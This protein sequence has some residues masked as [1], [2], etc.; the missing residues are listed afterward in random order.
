M[1]WLALNLLLFYLIEY[2]VLL[3]HEFG[4]VTAAKFV[5][6]RVLSVRIGYGRRLSKFTILGIPTIVNAIPL[7]GLTYAIPTERAW[8]KLKSWLFIAGGPAVHVIFLTIAFILS[9]ESFY[10]GY[11][12][13]KITSSIAP[14]ETFVLVNVVVL[15]LNIIPRRIGNPIGK[16]Y[17]DGYQLIVVPFLRSKQIDDL[18]RALPRVE[19]RELTREGNYSGAIEIYDRE[20]RVS[21]DDEL[22][23]HDRAIAVL[24]LGK[25]QE[26]QNTLLSLVGSESFT[27]KESALFLKNNIAWLD[28]VLGDQGDLSRADEYSESAYSSAPDVPMFCGTRGSVLIRLGRCDLG[29]NLLKRAFKVAGDPYARAAEA[30]FLALGHEMIGSRIDADKWLE[31]A[32]K[33]SPNYIL[34]ERFRHEIEALRSTSPANADE[35]LD[36]AVPQ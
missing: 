23:A 14:V 25:F 6:F 36:T 12:L 22:L 32:S 7:I 30:C 9:P 3:I 26:A 33:E 15:L 27:E 19:A 35:H 28:A 8:L 1:I 17:T 13:P 10:L 4:H 18:L 21:A 24:H 2:I 16:L 34:N 11:V 5:G 29:I 31:T 20:L